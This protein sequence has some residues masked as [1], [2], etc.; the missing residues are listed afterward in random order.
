MR[1][2]LK[3]VVAVA[4]AAVSI[5][6]GSSST[7]AGPAPVAADAKAGQSPATSA[8]GQAFGQALRSAVSSRATS[9]AVIDGFR[10]H[11]DPD[12]DGLIHVVE[13]D[14]VVVNAAD[15]ASQPP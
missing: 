3:V 12:G 6:C 7:P 10:V 15:I 11:P 13:G 4:V 9:T 5:R 1:R 14:G 8:F 2:L